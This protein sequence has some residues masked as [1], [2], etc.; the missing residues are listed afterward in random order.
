MLPLA[1][2]ALL[3]ACADFK[4]IGSTAQMW[5][6]DFYATEIS[7]PAQAGEWPHEDWVAEIGGTAL[8][9]LVEEAL[10]GNPG[11]QA[12]AARLASARALV[13]GAASAS[14]PQVNAFFSST[15]QRFT[16]N[17]QASPDIAG[18]HVSDNALGLNASYE[19]DFWGKHA[20]AR[21]AALSEAKAAEAELHAARLVLTAEIARI[22]VQIARQFAQ[23]DLV[24]QQID[25]REKF[26]R[27]TQMRF[28]VGLDAQGENHQVRGQVAALRIEQGQWEEAIALSRNQLAALLGQGPDRGLAIGRATLPEIDIPALPANLPLDLLGRRPDVLAARWRVDAAAGGI[29]NTKARFYPNINL[30]AFAGLASLGLSNLL[31]AGSQVEGTGPAISL[32][33]FDGGSLQAQLRD[34]VAAYDR[35][36]VAYHQALT[37]A[38]HDVADQVQSLRASESQIGNRQAATEAARASLELAQ[39]KLRAGGASLLQVLS[40]ELAWIEQCRLDLDAAARRAELRIGLFKA[41]GGGFDASRYGLTPAEAAKAAQP[42]HPAEKQA[43]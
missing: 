36:V 40:T 21:R 13:Q 35:A 10:T 33:I 5:T 32:P 12:A 37:Q 25:I 42:G 6:P 4:G 24:E 1:N 2:A 11:L 16:E 31:N 43:S 14:R 17:A 23:L 28:T 19:L 9:S 8:V 7:L 38:L 34:R 18:R 15:Y 3:T 29:D 39:R 30:V 27:L 41:L 20:A 22:W 26:A